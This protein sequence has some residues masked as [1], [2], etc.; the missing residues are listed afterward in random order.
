MQAVGKII[1]IEPAKHGEDG[2][3]EIAVEFTQIAPDD[4]EAIIRHVLRS[5]AT[6]QRL[7]LKKPVDS[8]VG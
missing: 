7:R 6:L 4:R 2:G 3:F 1:R 5:E 8:V